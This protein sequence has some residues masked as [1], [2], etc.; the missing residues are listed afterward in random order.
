[1]NPSRFLIVTDVI[2]LS[3]DG[4]SF[5]S[6]IRYEA[7]DEN[8]QPTTGGGSATGHAERIGLE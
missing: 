5:D 4:N 8:G 3:S 2:L 1:M 7:F 6:T